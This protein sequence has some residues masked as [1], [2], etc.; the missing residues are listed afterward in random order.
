V[1]ERTGASY[2]R[3][4]DIGASTEGIGA[5]G[6]STDGMTIVLG[7]RTEDIAILTRGKTSK[8]EQVY[9]GT[10][11][12]SCVRVSGPQHRV[13]AVAFYG[14]NNA[15][16]LAATQEGCLAFFVKDASGWRPQVLLDTQMPD[17]VAASVSPDFRWA[18]LGTASGRIQVWDLSHLERPPATV[19]A[20]LPW[21]SAFAW[22]S[23]SET[24]AR[25]WMI[26][27]NSRF[28]P[29]GAWFLEDND[30]V[31][32]PPTVSEI[33]P[34]T[35]IDKSGVVGVSAANGALLAATTDGRLL[36]LSSIG[37]PQAIVDR[38]IDRACEISSPLVGDAAYPGS[39]ARTQS[40]DDAFISEIMNWARKRCQATPERAPKE[41]KR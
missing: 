10:I 2:K 27:G 13:S 8:F 26:L 22:L 11:D 25:K 35:W 31:H 9:F 6:I 32:Q 7:Y 15:N 1:I 14:A 38:L 3:I 39:T 19:D 20:R 41:A 29:V 17:L 5:A 34:P 12:S 21:S 16:F 24:A 37:T 18:V 28:G 40:D 23:P 4:T 33:F 30:K 36:Q